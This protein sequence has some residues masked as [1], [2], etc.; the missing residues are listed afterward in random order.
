MV[1]PLAVKLGALDTDFYSCMRSVLL[2]GFRSFE[3]F[4]NRSVYGMIRDCTN[5]LHN[6][7]SEWIRV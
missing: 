4:G 5:K 7:K 1:F 2:F 3:L 6:R